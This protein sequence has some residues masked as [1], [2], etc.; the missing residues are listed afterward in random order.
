[1]L[2]S[3]GVLFES[4]RRLQLMGLTVETLKVLIESFCS[5]FFSY[6]SDSVS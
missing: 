3:D 4:L 6:F 5:C 2:Q 1:M